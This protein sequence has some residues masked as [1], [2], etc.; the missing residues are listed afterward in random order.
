[1]P[2]VFEWNA[3]KA[4]SNFQKHRISF[5][6]ACTVFD[7][8]LAVIFPDEDHSLEE[9]REI[10][11]G[12]SIVKRQII[13]CSTERSK[14]RIRIFSARRATRMEQKDYEEHRQG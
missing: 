9:A 4:R 14:D 13:V 1:M 5:D 8:P 7:D 12:H 11:I 2:L 6:E 3:Q 10:I